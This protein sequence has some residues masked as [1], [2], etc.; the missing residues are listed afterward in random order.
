MTRDEWAQ[1][2]AAICDELFTSAYRD[3]RKAAR[4]QLKGPMEEDYGG[5]CRGAVENVLKKHLI[6][7]EAE[8]TNGQINGGIST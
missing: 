4:L 7:A 5:W 1:L 3:G 2:I 6:A 8:M